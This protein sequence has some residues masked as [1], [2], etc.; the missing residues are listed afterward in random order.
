LLIF[1]P[2]Y[3]ISADSWSRQILNT[4]QAPLPITGTMLMAPTCWPRHWNPMVVFLSGGLLFITASRIGGIRKQTGP[5]RPMIPSCLSTAGSRIM[6]SF[7]LKMVPWISRSGNRF[8][9]SLVALKKPESDSGITDYPGVYRTTETS[10]LFG[11]PVERG[12]GI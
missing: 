4:G 8:H 5:G 7:R 9:H 11:S 10:L 1:M 2:R 6:L 3:Q 12:P